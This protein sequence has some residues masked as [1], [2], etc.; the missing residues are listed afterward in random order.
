MRERRGIQARI[1]KG[2]LVAFRQR[3]I[4]AQMDGRLIER[5]IEIASQSQTFDQG[6]YARHWIAVPCGELDESKIRIISWDM[7]SRK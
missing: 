2:T 3:L 6:P 4:Q 1:G 5:T 7:R